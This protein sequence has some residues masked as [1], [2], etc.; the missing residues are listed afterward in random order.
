MF[1]EV[2]RYL[3]ADVNEVTVPVRPGLGKCGQGRGGGGGARLCGLAGDQRLGHAQKRSQS[4][5]LGNA[6]VMIFL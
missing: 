2:T 6:S 3:V 1:V 4:V 5:A